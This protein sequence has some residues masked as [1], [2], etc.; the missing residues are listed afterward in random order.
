LKKAI[1]HTVLLLIHIYAFGIRL[2][3][4]TDTDAVKKDDKNY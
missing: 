2:I 4:S 1:R 3:L